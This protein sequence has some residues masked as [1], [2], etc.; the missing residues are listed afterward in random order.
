MTATKHAQRQTPEYR[1]FQQGVIVILRCGISFRGNE[2][3]GC[4][5]AQTRKFTRENGTK[6][7]RVGR[8]LLR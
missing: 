6:V 8:A 3:N 1:G 2:R 4:L 7:F 5:Q